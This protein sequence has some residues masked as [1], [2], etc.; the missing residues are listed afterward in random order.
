MME[1]TSEFMDLSFI[2]L[3]LFLRNLVLG[4][5]SVGLFI[6]AFKF[7]FYLIRLSR[8]PKKS[9]EYREL[10]YHMDGETLVRY[11]ISISCLIIINIL[12]YSF[13]EL[14]R[15]CT[16]IGIVVWS[17]YWVFDQIYSR[18][19]SKNK[20]Q[21]WSYISIAPLFSFNIFKTNL[22]ASTEIF[23]KKSCECYGSQN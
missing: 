12:F 21:K 10:S 8:L 22:S 9:R 15:S 7:T 17:L 11:A 20:P 14:G 4:T 3:L 18:F 2:D 19:L 13:F 16:H 1:S 23:R 6:G 5:A